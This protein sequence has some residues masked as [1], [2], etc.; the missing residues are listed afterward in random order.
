MRYSMPDKLSTWASAGSVERRTGP[1]SDT[2][3]DRLL[4]YLATETARAKHAG[5]RDA[6]EYL[7]GQAVEVARA[8]A[9]ARRWRKAA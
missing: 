5:D 3:A 9:E 2:Q 8:L 7:A 4:D 1:L 6:M